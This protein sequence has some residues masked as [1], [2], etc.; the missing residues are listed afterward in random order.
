M[1][2]K[3]IVV[4]GVQFLN[5]IVIFLSRFL[6]AKYL[7]SELYGVY[8][9]MTLIPSLC[10]LLANLGLG[11]AIS[12]YVSKEQMDVSKII[13][14]ATVYSLLVGGI[15][16]M[17]SNELFLAIYPS[18]EFKYLIKIVG[19]IPFLLF[20]YFTSYIFLGKQKTF[21]YFF[22]N[23]SQAFFTL[24]IFAASYNFAQANVMETAAVSWLAGS[25]L[26]LLYTLIRLFQNKCISFSLPTIKELNHLCRFGIKMY[27]T[28]VINFM[29]Y[30][31]DFFI[32]GFFL[33]SK[34]LG[35]YAL[36]VAIADS[37]GKISQSLSLIVFSK[38]PALSK[39]KSNDLTTFALKIN[40]VLTTGAIAF[41]TF[42]G[43]PIVDYLF[44]GEYNDSMTV[45]YY[46]APGIITISIFRIIYHDL[47]GRDMAHFGVQATL[48]SFM[49]TLLLDFLLIPFFELKGAAIASSLAY[50]VSCFYILKSYLKLT[51][52]KYKELFW[53][54]R[55]ETAN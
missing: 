13:F 5:I 51:S 33:S 30:R 12:Y 20:V 19:T 4:L 16:A 53:I 24:M 36:A 27:M 32:I 45:F 17:I 38:I 22:I 7:G 2:K 43:E 6:F 34:H 14:S 25:L 40:I 54:K 15:I 21:D 44:N 35:I 55:R 52:V 31:L 50:T 1:V 9:L 10:V 41:L 11:H 23:M 47:A 49:A 3:T 37:V 39:E 28:S 29:N 26:S 8:N 42:A 46:L 18:L 48:V